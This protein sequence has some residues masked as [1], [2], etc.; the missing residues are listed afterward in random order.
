MFS[1]LP[2]CQGER[3]PGMRAWMLVVVVMRLWRAGS[4]PGSRVRVFAGLGGWALIWVMMASATE[5]ASWRPGRR[6]RVR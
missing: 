4:L 1:L 2:G 6:R 5:P 3:G